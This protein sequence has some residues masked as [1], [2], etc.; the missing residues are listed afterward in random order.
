MAQTGLV[1]RNAAQLVQN[2]PLPP[3]PNVAVQRLWFSLTRDS[4][5]RSLLVLPVGP[6][7]SAQRM[8]LGLTKMACYEAPGRVLL[9]DARLSVESAGPSAVD[10][11]PWPVVHHLPSFDVVKLSA[12]PPG[13]LDELLRRS[14]EWLAALDNLGVHRRRI[15]VVDTILEE[16]RTI[17]L[18]RMSD[19]VLLLVKLGHSL[20]DDAKR[21][22][23]LLG[24]ERIAGVA[25]L[26]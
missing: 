9:V 25:A 11:E 18:C 26:R 14:D 19:R 5:W 24:R 7:I 17:P 15:L 3:R 1:R 4:R 8:A 2:D 20:G 10:G 13:H 21:I 23:D 16:T 6:E 12:L 22:I